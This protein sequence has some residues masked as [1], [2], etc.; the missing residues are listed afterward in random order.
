MSTIRRNLSLIL[1]FLFAVACLGISSLF[2]FVSV[3]A[4]ENHTMFFLPQSNLDVLDLNSS[5]PA[6]ATVYDGGTAIITEN[7]KLYIYDEDSYVEYSLLVSN[8]PGQIRHFGDNLL[9]VNDN[10]QLYTID[11]TNLSLKPQPFTYNGEQITS[12]YFEVSGNYLATISNNKIFVYE[13][14]GV[15]AV[16]KLELPVNPKLPSPV[17]INQ[18]GKVFFIRLS[19][20]KLCVYDGNELNGTPMLSSGDGIS[21]MVSHNGILYYTQDN[22]VHCISEN[23]LEADGISPT[24]LQCTTEFQSYDLGSIQNPTDMHFY[25]DNLVITDSQKNA[26]QQFSIVNNELVFTGKAIAKDKTAFN[27]ISENAIKIAQTNKDVAILD[28]FKLTVIPNE[29]DFDRYDKQNYDNYLLSELD[30]PI[31]FALGNQTI[32]LGYEDGIKKLNLADKTIDQELTSLSNVKSLLFFNNAYYVLCSDETLTTVYVTDESLSEMQ[33]VAEYGYTSN[34]FTV[35]VYGNVFTYNESGV[36]KNGEIIIAD[37]DVKGL[38]TDLNGNLYSLKANTVKYLDLT[39]EVW[40]DFVIFN[41]NVKSVAHTIFTND[42]YV[43]TE[44]SEFV[45]KSTPLDYASILGINLPDG[46]KLNDQTVTEELK[47]YTINDNCYSYEIDVIG[48][49]KYKNQVQP[50]SEYAFINKTTLNGVN[51]EIEYL[52]LAGEKGVTLTHTSSATEKFVTYDSEVSE[53]AYVAT[54]VN[55]YY[56]PI[57]TKSNAY[58]LINEENVLRLKKG[59][60]FSPINKF[61]FGGIDFYK[62]TIETQENS[63]LG[64]IPVNFTVRVLSEDVTY[65]T[66]SLEQVNLTTLYQ[67]ST[68][69]TAIMQIPQGETIRVYENNDGVLKVWFKTADGFVEGYISSTAIMDN[70]NLQIR[71]ILIVLAV[72]A[73]LCGTVTYFV[74]RSKRD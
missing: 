36:Y 63:V 26:I 9:L 45:Y 52:L 74:L 17:C 16:K 65:S 28:D 51:G 44:D 49:V 68:L 64:Y 48:G 10:L 47:V 54:D 72:S 71:N 8:N 30:N 60:L 40:K 70:P 38:F 4:E 27:R 57:I 12:S 50:E 39:Q 46:F 21:N 67:D 7:K 35:D 42:L 32:L 41:T 25:G 14:S 18:D 5:A 13:L 61:T 66:Y 6:H 11:L 59:V 53:K 37:S 55:V 56:F 20:S 62:A 73:C 23:V 24:T 1:L 31:T 29:N 58:T 3:D 43:I 2:G 22:A 19:D 69:T 33:K 34:G 15:T